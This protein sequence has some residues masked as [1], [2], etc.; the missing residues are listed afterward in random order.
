MVGELCKL[1]T[2]FVSDVLGSVVVVGFG[3]AIILA[4]H[5]RIKHALHLIQLGELCRSLRLDLLS[6]EDLFLNL[7]CTLV[8]CILNLLKGEWKIL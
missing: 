1:V 7:V 3:V 2:W 6:H 4:H 5:V 8:D